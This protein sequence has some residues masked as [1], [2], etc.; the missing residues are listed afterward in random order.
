M[1][2]ISFLLTLWLFLSF[3]SNSQDIKVIELEPVEI[4]PSDQILVYS[5]FSKIKKR[6]EGPA[7]THDK[8]SI[9]SGFTN[10]SDGKIQIE[11]IELFFNHK[12]TVNSE[13]FY[14]QPVV[15]GVEN[16]LPGQHLLGF[17]EKYLVTS[18]LKDRLYIDLSSQQ[19]ELVPHQKIFLGIRFL[20]NVNP[21]VQ[22]KFNVTVIFGQADEPTYLQDSLEN[23][24]L[25]ISST[26]SDSVGLKYSV[27]YKLK[28]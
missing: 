25:Q 8:L 23:P 7:R 19:L 2:R 9:I 17:S 16:G 14:I 4:I 27:V 1:K 26:S 28:E 18:K 13:G 6:H 24:F 11:G 21:E 15:V 3:E 22:N 5:N 10:P 20:E 12:W